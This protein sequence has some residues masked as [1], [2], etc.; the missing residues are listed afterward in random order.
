MD[1]SDPGIF[2][3]RSA[4]IRHYNLRCAAPAALRNPQTAAPDR[5]SYRDETEQ[6]ASYDI[7]IWIYFIITGS[8][9]WERTTPTAIPALPKSAD[10]KSFPVGLEELR[11]KCLAFD[12]V[13]RPTLSQIRDQLLSICDE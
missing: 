2:R 5:K 6:T 13:Q 3:V 10:L 7:G 9:L 11:Q 1:D 4:A 8:W 12:P